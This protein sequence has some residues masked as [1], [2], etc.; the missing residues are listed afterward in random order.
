[1][2]RSIDRPPPDLDGSTLV[3]VGGTVFVDSVTGMVLSRLGYGGKRGYERVNIE[4]REVKA[5]RLVYET[6]VGPIPDGLS[7]NHIDGDKLNNRPDNL[8][9]ATQS[10]QVAHAYR[11]GLRVGNGLEGKA[12]GSR[13]TDEQIQQVVD[14][15]RGT[16]TEVAHAL[17]IARSYAYEIRSRRRLAVGDRERAGCS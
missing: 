1:M 15:P 16:I 8:E 17:G 9:P 10:E 11:I 12:R 4:G 6:V 3:H 7:I 14:A 13:L 5:H 2:R